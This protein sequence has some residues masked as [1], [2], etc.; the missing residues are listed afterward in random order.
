ELIGQVE[1]T[2][3]EKDSVQFTKLLIRYSASGL[4]QARP[5]FYVSLGPSILG[6]VV[7][8]RRCGLDRRMTGF[9]GESQ[10]RLSMG[11]GNTTRSL[12]PEMSMRSSNARGGWAG[13]SGLD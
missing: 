3:Q 12:R 13:V 6:G 2:Q 1:G 7:L 11:S 9:V 10:Q 8:V 4:T 5:S